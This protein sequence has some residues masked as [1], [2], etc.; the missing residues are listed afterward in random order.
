MIRI[1]ASLNNAYHCCGNSRDL[2]HISRKLGAGPSSKCL[3]M[4]AVDLRKPCTA[5]PF[6]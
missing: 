2:T 3:G 4:D 1:G 5:N 6:E